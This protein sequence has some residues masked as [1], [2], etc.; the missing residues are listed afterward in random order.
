M[1]LT[2]LPVALVF[3]LLHP[4][5]HINMACKWKV[6]SVWNKFQFW[7]RDFDQRNITN[8]GDFKRS[9]NTFKKQANKQTKIP[10]LRKYIGTFLED[11]RSD[12]PHWACPFTGT[13][14]CHCSLVNNHLQSMSYTNKQWQSYTNRMKVKG[15]SWLSVAFSSK[16]TDLYINFMPLFLAP[17]I[18]YL[19]SGTKYL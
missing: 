17:K 11:Y 12:T 13:R 6:V 1:L 9:S 2:C 3:R 5:S 10:F 19:Y 7:P 4:G 15:S 8:W 14:L 16:W 18:M